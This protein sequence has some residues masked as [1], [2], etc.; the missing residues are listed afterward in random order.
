[1]VTCWQ[2]KNAHVL[3]INSNVL[4]VLRSWHFEMLVALPF[5]VPPPL[6]FQFPQLT[7]TTKQKCKKTVG[8]RG[9][10]PSISLRIHKHL[11]VF[12]K[13]G[14]VPLTRLVFTCEPKTASHLVTIYFLNEP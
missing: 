8:K 13:G 14:V 1:M 12:S 5:L 7:D 9:R 6:A 10:N 4:L 2:Y 3:L 11:Y